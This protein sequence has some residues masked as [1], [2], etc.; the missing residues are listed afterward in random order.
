MPEC[1]E[2]RNAGTLE[3]PVGRCSRD[4]KEKERKKKKEKRKEKKETNK[5][6]EKTNNQ[7]NLC[8]PNEDFNESSGVLFPGD[9]QTTPMGP[10]TNRVST[11]SYPMNTG[12][13]GLT[14]ASF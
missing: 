14:R 1:P 6:T 9:Q 7:T 2:C 8:S 5:R 13:I 4:K 3:R 11:S 12:A 10:Y